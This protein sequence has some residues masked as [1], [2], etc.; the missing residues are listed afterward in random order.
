MR[1]T[2]HRPH[3][4]RSAQ[5]L[6]LPRLADADQQP[7]EILRNKKSFQPV[8]IARGA[9]QIRQWQRHWRIIAQPY[10]IA[11]DTRLIGKINQVLAPFRL[12]DPVR[13]GQQPVQITIAVDQLGCGLYPD[14][15]HPRHII[16]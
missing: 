14:P 7:P 6:A 13:L 4:R 1:R 5:C 2:R 10:K 9:F 11:A 15:G 3:G 12:F 16:G 8:H